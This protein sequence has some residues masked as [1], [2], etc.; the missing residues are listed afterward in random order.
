MGEYNLHFGKDYFVHLKY[1][2]KEQLISSHI[3][4]S[5]TWASKHAGMDLMGGTGKSALD[6]GCA[7]G[8]GV[9]LLRSLGY[10]SW[11]TDVSSYGLLQGKE[12][13]KENVFV[14]S[15]A[16]NL[17]FSRR[18]DLVTSFEVLEHLEHPLKALHDLYDSTRCILLCTTPNRTFERITKRLLKGFD[19]THINV[20]TPKEWSE[21]IRKNLQCRFIKIQ[22]FVDV[23]FQVRSTSFYRSFKLP[24]GMETRILI[25]K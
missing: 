13:L 6:V 23:S 17:P 1:S 3:Y 20:K 25:C 9:S 19:K 4:E 24:F 5:L 16:Q 12:K 11:G 15:D 10:D 8:Y 14:A 21:L 7:S 2:E 22:S 18:F